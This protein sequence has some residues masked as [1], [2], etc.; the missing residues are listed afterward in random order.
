MN[1]IFI[2]SICFINICPSIVSSSAKKISAEEE[3]KKMAFAPQGPA[4]FLAIFLNE[5]EFR[6]KQESDIAKNATVSAE[7]SKAL[8]AKSFPIITSASLLTAV[9]TKGEW[10]ENLFTTHFIEFLNSAFANKAFTAIWKDLVNTPATS[11]AEFLARVHVPF[12]L[13]LLSSDLINLFYYRTLYDPNWTVLGVRPLFN[14]DEW[15]IRGLEAPGNFGDILYV[16]VPKSYLKALG[17]PEHARSLGIDN[18]A[19]TECERALGL[20]I[21]HMKLVGEKNIN[22]IYEKRKHPATDKEQEEINILTTTALLADVFVPRDKYTEQDSFPGWVVY[23][24]GHGGSGQQV[25][26]LGLRSFGL[27][28]DALASAPVKALFI[29]SC[30]AGGE[31]VQT[32]LDFAA[33]VYKDKVGERGG[34]PYPF[35]IVV[36]SVNETET[37]LDF[38]SINFSSLTENDIDFITKTFRVI[39]LKGREFGQVATEI[40][41]KG[42]LPFE[43]LQKLLFPPVATRKKIATMAQIIEPGAAPKVLGEGIFN[44]TPELAFGRTAKL[45]LPVPSSTVPLTHLA[46]TT[47]A[48]FDIEINTPNPID[49]FTPSGS[50]YVFLQKVS[51]TKAWGIAGILKSFVNGVIDDPRTARIISVDEIADSTER[52]AHVVIA[53]NY[54]LEDDQKQ[55]NSCKIF[56]TDEQGNLKVIRDCRAA[57]LQMSYPNFTEQDAYARVQQELSSLKKDAKQRQVDVLQKQKE[58][59]AAEEKKRVLTETLPTLAKLHAQLTELSQVLQGA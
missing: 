43:A 14:F 22:E 15:E 12:E 56:L 20:K 37:Y 41:K 46:I 58:Q 50:T 6:G 49:I 17:C 9:L 23:A 53:L 45:A 21:N 7:L 4:R 36:Q 13:R 25:M 51:T 28:L 2:L 8:L 29:N 10:F 24:T 32:A 34:N 47:D 27:F 1:K 35:P 5:S 26:S 30:F 52:A 19:L 59:K 57:T 18:P 39:R 11:T 40:Q 16:M 3:K 31:S 48:F 33:S 44:I 54:S 38:D 42:P 55:A